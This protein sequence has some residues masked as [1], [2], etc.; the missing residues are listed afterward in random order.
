MSLAKE[1][2]RLIGLYSLMFMASSFLGIN[3]IYAELSTPKLPI[4]LLQ[5]AETAAMISLLIIGQHIL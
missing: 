1:C 3:V 5:T 4:F 2:T